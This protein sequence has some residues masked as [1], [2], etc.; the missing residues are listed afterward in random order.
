MSLI[1][2]R[3]ADQILNDLVVTFQATQPDINLNEASTIYIL[4]QIYAFV[5]ALN[6]ATAQSFAL[7]SF[8]ATAT[9]DDLTALGEDRGVDRI[10][11]TYATVV[12]E[13]N[14]VIVDYVNSYTIP[15]SSSF[16][17][18][19]DENGLY[20]Q[21]YTTTSITLPASSVSVTGIAQANEIGSDY[22][23]AANTIT[24]FITTIK[25]IDTVTNPAAASGGLDEETDDDYRS[26]IKT[27]LQN[28]GARNTIAGY[29]NSL[30]SF[31]CKS[32][33]VYA[34]TAGMP[35]YITAVVTSPNTSNTIP[36]ASE[37]NGWQ[38][39]INAD[40]YRAVCD[41]ITVVAP[42]AITVTVSAMITEYATSFSQDMVRNAARDAIINYIN[43]LPPGSDVYKNNIMGILHDTAGVIDFIWYLPTS[44]ISIGNT[45]KAITSTSNVTIN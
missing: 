43:N 7:S 22:N 41:N 34:A 3:S 39:Q 35:N 27:T 26:R 32:A 21:F 42:T 13:F 40:E 19:P 29:E 11:G 30:L 20:Y 44:N 6:V 4:F 36:T 12:L 37:L 5:A 45:Q 38:T 17:T 1:N 28:N 14:R 16:S 31:G 8:L 9:G 33:Y 23:V 18:L 24:N 25:G 2:N 15:V 10:P